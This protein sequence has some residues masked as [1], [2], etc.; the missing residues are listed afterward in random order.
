MPTAKLQIE[1][2]EE[3]DV[4][5]TGLEGQKQASP[6]ELTFANPDVVPHNWVLRRNPTLS[7]R[8]AI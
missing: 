4:F 8:L 1:A 5:D 3:L 2:G 6:V 7:L